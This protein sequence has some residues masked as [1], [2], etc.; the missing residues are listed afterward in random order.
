MSES[1]EE[2]SRTVDYLRG[3]SAD[4]QLWEAVAV[5]SSSLSRRWAEIVQSDRSFSIRDLRRAARAVTAYR[6]RMATRS[7]PFGLMAGVALAHIGGDVDETTVR[8]G[9]E[10]RRFARPEIGWLLAL[11]A[12]I[13]RRPQVLRQLRVTGN[14]LCFPRGNRLVLP[15]VPHTLPPASGSA[16]DLVEISVRYSAPVRAAMEYARLPVRG[17]DLG[18]Q[19]LGRFPRASAQTV[20]GMLAGLVERD[21]LLTE[22]RPPMDATDPLAHV[23]HVLETV[24]PDAVPELAELRA[25]GGELD[26]YVQR[27]LGQGGVEWERVTERMRALRDE[28]HLVQVDLSLDVDVVLPHVVAAEAQKAASLLWRIGPEPPA[29][30]SLTEFHDAFLERYGVGRAVPLQEVL[31][32]EA[33]IGAPAEYYRPPSHRRPPLAGKQDTERNRLLMELA[34][35]TLLSGTEEVVLTDDHPLVRRLSRQSGTPPASLELMTELLAETPASVTAGDFRLVLARGSAS[36]G[37]TFGRFV[38]LLPEQTRSALSALADTPAGGEEVRAQVLFQANHGRGA[39]V[40]QAPRLLEHV[41]PVGVFADR[42][43][44]GTIDLD[45]LALR[46]D[47]ERFY[48]VRCSDGRE[49]VPTS[50][51]W[52]DVRYF[53]PN[54]ARLMGA[55]GWGW[56]AR[57]WQ[58]WDWGM[59][60]LLPR[61]PRVRYGR[62]VLALAQWRPPA[63]VVDQKAPFEQWS[64]EVERWRQ[65]LAVPERVVL[66]FADQR[67]ELTLTQE[68]HLREFRHELGRDR[69]VTVFEALASTEKGTGWLSSEDGP[70]RCELVLPMTRRAEAAAKPR[71]S[72]MRR[73]GRS[74]VVICEA[75]EHLPGSEWLY[76]QVHCSAERHRELLTTHLPRLTDALPG[77]VDRWFFIRYR[78][79]DPVLRLR[80]HGDPQVLSGALLPGLHAWAANLRGHRLISHLSLQPYQPE[81]E[82][83]GGPEAIAAAERVFHADSQ[84]VLATLALLESGHLPLD[85]VVIAAAGYVDL[86]RHLFPPASQQSTEPPWIET[87]L[88]TYPKGARHKEFQRRRRDVLAL[89]DPYDA[90]AA[91]RAGAGALTQVWQQRAGAVADY[92]RLLRELGGQASAAPGEVWASLAHM[93]HNRLLG[94][95]PES[96]AVSLAIARGA[97]QAHQDRHAQEMRHR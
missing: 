2:A 62:C 85:P 76:A 86:L 49:V 82:R 52:L 28:D 70:Y 83:Y 23:L 71:K 67:L 56:G 7:T 30:S 34:Q 78:D 36:R 51:N 11:V 94:I 77:E 19:L 91:E 31:D 47:R 15:Y 46:A 90:K 44:P 3:M 63:S 22:L 8:F 4:P 48:L 13:E 38:H 24:D 69:E 35:E 20:D 1:A 79:P 89:I 61:T 53:A 26:D 93:H 95:D 75:E 39:N 66:A 55:L 5:S 60:S 33:G 43:A 27:P 84:A 57:Q 92:G 64:G 68:Q 59:T 9:C 88:R 41:I 29:T 17:S 12:G 42:G 18:R 10:H 50:Q 58:G 74:P 21:I 80:F 40:A 32:P 6:L 45:D 87:L 25:V 14:N 96:E 72:S 54:V 16:R 37:A 97:V 73:A 81:V 65:R